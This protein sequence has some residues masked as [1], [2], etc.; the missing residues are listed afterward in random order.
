MLYLGCHG[1]CRRTNM[2]GNLPSALGALASLET[3]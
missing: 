2:T 3:L 1:S